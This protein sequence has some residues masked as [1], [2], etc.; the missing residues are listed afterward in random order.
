MFEQFDYDIHQLPSEQVS[1]SNIQ[2]LVGRVEKYLRYYNG[3]TMN[4]DES[5]KVIIFA[6]SGH[7]VE[8]QIKT[9]DGELFPLQ[10]I[11]KPLV[12]PECGVANTIPKL[13]F[14]DAC[15]NSQGVKNDTTIMTIEGNYCIE[16]ATTSGHRADA[17]GPESAWMPLLADK[18][19]R[20]NDF[21]HNVIAEVKKQIFKES[22]K[23][24]R[25][26]SIDNLTVGKFKLYYCKCKRQYLVF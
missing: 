15:R 14:I 17:L 22:D 12:N 2:K 1:S 23:H 25:P 21:Y 19:R 13:F 8:N 26:Q 16:Y 20:N 24:Q 10:D 5:T 3:A 6:F 9:N 7:G 18:F 4:S 11:V